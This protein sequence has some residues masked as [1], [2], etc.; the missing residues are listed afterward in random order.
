MGAKAAY[1]W[2]QMGMCGKVHAIIVGI[3]WKTEGFLQLIITG[4]E[5]CM[6]HYEPVSSHPSMEWKHV[7]TQDQEIQKYVTC[8][9][10]DADTVLQH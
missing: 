8:Q 9:Q 2:A 3:S 7:I 1:R 6:S 10:S 4:D 5:T